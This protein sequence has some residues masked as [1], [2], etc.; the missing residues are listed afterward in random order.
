[1]YPI[2][3]DPDSVSGSSCIHQE[4]APR[5]PGSC[6]AANA[7]ATTRVKPDYALDERTGKGLVVFSLTTDMASGGLSYDAGTWHS[8]GISVGTLWGRAE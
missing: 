7:F 8:G 6:V 5:P 3:S 4:C 1:M 2:A